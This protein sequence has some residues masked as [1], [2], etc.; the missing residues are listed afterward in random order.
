MLRNYLKVTV[1]N[2]ARHKGYSLISIF[3]LSMGMAVCILIFQYVYG[4]FSFD[5]YHENKDVIFRVNSTRLQESGERNPSALTPYRMAPVLAEQFPEIERITRFRNLPVIVK[6]G[7]HLFSESLLLSDPDALSMFSFEMLAGNPGA[8]LPDK[9]SIILSEAAAEKYFGREDPMGQTLAIASKSKG[10]LGD[11]VVTG[12]V[13]DLPVNSTIRFD[14]MVSMELIVDALPTFFL[15][16]WGARTTRTYVQLKEGASATALQQ[17][18]PAALE[19]HLPDDSPHLHNYEFYLQPL[20]DIH[21]DARFASLYESVNNPVYLLIL[22]AI[23]LVILLMACINYSSLAIGRSSTRLRE[24]GTRKL[25]GAVR[26]DLVNQFLG[27]ALVLC[28]VALLLAVV[29]AELFL[30][31]FNSLAQASL[32]AGA[33][34]NWS[35]LGGLAA[36]LLV[37]SLLCGGMPAVYSARF[38]PI[39]IFRGSLKLGSGGVYT[40]SLLVIQFALSIL[41]VTC[42]LLMSQQLNYMKSCNLGFNGEQVAVLKIGGSRGPQIVQQLRTETQSFGQVQSISGTSESIGREDTYG[43]IGLEAEGVKVDAYVFG[44]DEQYLNTF[45]IPLV[46]GRN[47]SGEFPSDSTRSLIVNEAFVSSCGWESGLG[48]QVKVG[49]PGMENHAATIIGVVKDYHFQ[50]LHAKI[51]PAVLHMSPFFKPSF[52][53]VRIGADDLPG[54]VGLLRDKWASVAPEVP[55]EYFFLDQDFD[56][57]YRAEEKWSEIIGLAALF[58]I[59]IA[60][61]GLMGVTTLVLSRRTKEIGIRRVLGAT[62]AAIV[63]LVGREF[64]YAVLV[65]NLLAWPIA[66]YAMNRWLQGF[67]YRIDMPWPFFALSGALALA[68]AMTGVAVLSIRAAMANPIN[69][70]RQE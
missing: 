10:S 62:V 51:E 5:R 32:T 54:T 59:G 61:L 24:V 6:R 35:T 12:V 34:V 67:A 15:E 33:I 2:L 55:F 65:A 46:E 64:V 39:D 31:V 3:G 23:G 47:F 63:R 57:Q 26:R 28:F 36:L 1:R 56:R 7:E 30:P 45:E 52:A 25:F 4:E 40:R 29:L 17:K 43:Y 20:T 37:V 42:V 53:A 19:P 49:F 21:F 48:K 27:E 8:A 66:Y 16:S 50:S 41:F 60:F 44:V 13:A 69:S 70:L 68:V 11:F 14:F 38:N 22:G 58:A 18:I 9:H